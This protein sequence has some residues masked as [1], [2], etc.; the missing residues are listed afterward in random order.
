MP[1]IN[2]C[3]FEILIMRKYYTF[4]LLQDSMIGNIGDYD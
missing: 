4:I 2:Q 1:E 3:L